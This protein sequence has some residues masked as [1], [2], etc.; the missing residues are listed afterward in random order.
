MDSYHA[1]YKA[2]RRYWPRLLLVLC[3]VLLMFALNPQNQL[4]VL[5]GSW[6]SSTVG[7]GQGWGLQV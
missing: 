6:N 1:H 3:F 2:K 5:T 4:A 7:L